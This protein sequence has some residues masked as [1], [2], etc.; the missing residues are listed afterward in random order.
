M[1]FSLQRLREVKGF[2]GAFYRIGEARNRVA[3][4]TRSAVNFARFRAEQNGA[5]PSVTAIIVGRNDDYMADFRQRLEATIR[6]N[7]HFLVDEI[8]FIEWNPPPDRELLSEGLTKKFD[9]VRAYVVP[10][11]IHAQVCDNPRIPLLEYHAKNVGIRR[12]TTPWI[13]TT[14]ADAAF[15]P[16]SIRTLLHGSLSND[17]VWTTQR[18]DIAW[19]EGRDRPIN[20][21]DTLR[22]RRV[23]PYNPMGT[24]EFAFASRELWHRAR[25]YDESLSRHRIGADMRGVAQMLSLGAQTRKAGNVLHMAHPTSCSEGVQAHHGEWAPMDGIPYA[26]PDSWGLAERE[27]IK[28]AERIWLLK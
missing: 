7:H 10:P 14:N 11:E 18:V 8:I 25:G 28:I 21:L 5:R 16:D 9:F 4:A 22:Y 15:S 13:I 24:G 27:E 3:F 2:R 23:S 12:A 17:I 6:W 19:R 20:F 26:N 1:D